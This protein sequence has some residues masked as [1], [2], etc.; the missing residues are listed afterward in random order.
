M[1]PSR[2]NSL[3]VTSRDHSA[4]AELLLL[5]AKVTGSGKGVCSCAAD[6]FDSGVM[7]DIATW[8]GIV[9]PQQA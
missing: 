9:Q 6:G 2:G 3:G 5:P 1:T 8:H 4:L 7:L